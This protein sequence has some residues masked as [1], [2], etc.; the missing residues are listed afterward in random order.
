MSGTPDPDVGALFDR[1]APGYDHE[2]LRLFPFSAD[3]LVG[4]ARI[5]RGERVLDVA[6]GT[7]AVALAAAQMATPGG[8]V[9]GIDLS[10]P[11]LARAEEKAR[12]LGLSNIDLH[13][14]DAGALDFRR[15]YF[16]VVVCGFGL[17]FLPD[18]ASV[19]REWVRVARP[20]GRLAF[21]VFAPGSFEPL[22]SMLRQSLADAG[23]APAGLHPPVWQRLAD[24]RACRELC[25]GAGLEEVCVVE[26]A[27]GYHLADA[28]G[29]WDVVWNSGMRAL[30]EPLRTAQRE[31][32]RAAHLAEVARTATA[33]G[34]RL[35]VNVR[36][37]LACKPVVPAPGA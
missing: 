34:I 36:F 13:C 25:V 37:V 20:G 28:A 31:R 17:F 15:D 2:V 12:A 27:L 29:W 11:M 14:M 19:L 32:L 22:A 8:R 5:R 18:M 4:H 9:T 7:G 33:D 21:S 24:A 26:E 35:E 23:A 30:V 3:R 6:T 16:D 10:E 1:L